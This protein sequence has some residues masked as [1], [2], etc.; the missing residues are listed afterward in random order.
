MWRIGG[1]RGKEEWWT[2]LGILFIYGRVQPEVCYFWS[3]YYMAWW[4]RI[5]FGHSKVRC[6]TMLLDLVHVLIVGTFTP[7]LGK[8]HSW[9]T[10][11]KCGSKFEM[12]LALVIKANS[13]LAT[14]V[15]MHWEQRGAIRLCGEQKNKANRS[16]SCLCVYCIQLLLIIC[17]N[18]IFAYRYPLLVY[19]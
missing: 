11:Y 1:R 13:A 3:W 8:V 16:C 15:R 9:C 14:T 4:C 19:M 12:G 18:P 10:G 7:W 6:A 17:A 5:K 2:I